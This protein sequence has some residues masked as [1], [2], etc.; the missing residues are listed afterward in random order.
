MVHAPVFDATVPPRLADDPGFG[1]VSSQRGN[2]PLEDVRLHADIAGLTASV[3][4]RVTFCNDGVDRVEA[5]YVFPVPELAAVNS[6]QIRTGSTVIDGWLLERAHAR[7]I[8]AAIRGERDAAILEQERDDVVTI[9]VGTIARNERV[10]IRLILHTRLTY[11]DGQVFFRF[12]LVVAP[13]YAPGVPLV[14]EPV[15]KGTAEDTDLVPDASRVAPPVDSA[16]RVRLSV[17]LSMAGG[18]YAIGEIGCTLRTHI[19]SAATDQTVRIEALPGQRLDRDLV[20]R[21]RISASPA[22]VVAVD[23]RGQRWARG[24][25]RPDFAS[26]HGRDTSH[27]RAQCRCGR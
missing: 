15:G 13:R 20:L 23:Q 18:A 17:S 3:D 16:G 2:L 4:L 1:Y 11:T 10:E 27:R 14:G 19:C 22:V 6:L 24:D 7:G 21:M 8:Y 9:R 26:A 5:T 12:P 25:V